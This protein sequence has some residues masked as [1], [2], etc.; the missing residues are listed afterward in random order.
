MYL[1][2]N[3]LI[4]DHVL[5]HPLFL[6]KKTAINKLQTAA[7]VQVYALETMLKT[8]IE[9]YIFINRCNTFEFNHAAICGLKMGKVVL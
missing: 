8:R 5:N 4:Q 9:Q 3:Q 2:L 1:F 6:L 7:S